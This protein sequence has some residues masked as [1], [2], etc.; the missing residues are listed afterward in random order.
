M[1]SKW[2]TNPDPIVLLERKVSNNP[3]GRP[4]KCY[5]ECAPQTSMSKALKS[6]SSATQLEVLHAAVNV[7]KSLGIKGLVKSLS[8]A[9]KNLTDPNAIP[10]NF[11]STMSPKQALAVMSEGNMSA[12][13]D[14]RLRRVIAKNHSNE[15]PAYKNVKD[16]K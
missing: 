13:S 1:K 5:V 6:T 7:L 2:Y 16:A 3:M 4:K 11:K 15:L 9:L 10:D 12:N 8:I 14:K